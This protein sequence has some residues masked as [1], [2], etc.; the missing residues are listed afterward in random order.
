[1]SSKWIPVED[2]LPLNAWGAPVFN[3]I[4]VLTWSEYH[5]G[6]PVVGYYLYE[7]RQ[8]YYDAGPLDGITHWTPF[9]PTPDKE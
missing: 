7:E 2:T 6:D 1:M 5:G 3:S 4:Q 8:W 9:P